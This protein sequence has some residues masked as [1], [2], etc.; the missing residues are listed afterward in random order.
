MCSL[1]LI[2]LFGTWRR[3]EGEKKGREERKGVNPLWFAQ[4]E[5]EDKKRVTNQKHPAAKVALSVIFGGSCF[6]CS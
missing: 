6:C 5:E 1:D 2:S 4:L 3:E